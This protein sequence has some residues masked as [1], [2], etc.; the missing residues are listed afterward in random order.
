LQKKLPAHIVIP[1]W[2]GGGDTMGFK[3]KIIDFM[4][5]HNMTASKLARLAGVCAHSI[6]NFTK[7]EKSTITLRIAQQLSRAMRTYERRIVENANTIKQQEDQK[8]N[9]I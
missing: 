5:R 1:R 8:E 7:D 9:A 6:R 4:G 2:K 3:R